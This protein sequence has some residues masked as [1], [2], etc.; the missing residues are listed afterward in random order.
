MN[1][2]EVKREQEGSKGAF[3]YE[4]NGKRLGESTYTMAGP[5]KLIIDHTEADD[6]LRGNGAG[7]HLVASVVEYARENNMKIMP[8]C[9][10]A[11]LIFQKRKESGRIYG[12]KRKN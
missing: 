1:I 9:P 3:Y 5:D 7:A 4:E 10:F 2:P 8:L 12:G 11:K 6:S